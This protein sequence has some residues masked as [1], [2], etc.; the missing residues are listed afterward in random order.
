MP[1]ILPHMLIRVA[2]VENEAVFAD[3]MQMILNNTGTEISC[4]HIFSNSA[5]ALKKLPGLKPDI[6]LM[7]LDL[8]QGQL[9]GI[10]CITRL[11]PQ[12]PGTLF[13]VLTVYEDHQKVF[14]ALSAGA[15]GYVLKSAKPEKIIEAVRELYEGG[16]PMS[17]SIARQIAGS[18][19]K[20]AQT[21]T[22]ESELLTTREKEVIELISRGKLEKEVAAE[23]FIS[24]KTV[25]SHISN[26]YGKLH[27]RTRVEALNKYFGR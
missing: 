9:N 22:P 2:I 21:P 5:E 23:L 13:M 4:P 11:Q 12:M 7:D 26:I 8:G 18:F 3:A 16:A 20:P 24:L 25:K 1:Q 14:D 19:N 15:L 6:V 27:V 17:P 10:D